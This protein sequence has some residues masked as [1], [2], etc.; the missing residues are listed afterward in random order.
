MPAAPGPSVPRAELPSGL[1]ERGHCP[2][3]T[4][5]PGFSPGPPGGLPADRV[6]G[7]PGAVS[8]D[9]RRFGITPSPASAWWVRV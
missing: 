5:G 9:H 2:R 3:S 1:S 7:L 6:A 4:V 8:P